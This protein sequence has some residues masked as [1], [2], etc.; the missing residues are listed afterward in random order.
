MSIKVFEQALSLA[1]ITSANLMLL[2]IL[3]QEE[4]G[5]PEALIYPNI[6]YYPGWNGRALNYT[7]NIGINLKMKDYR[8]YNHGALKLIHPV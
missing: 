3:S 5:S 4:E 7:K 6:D 2:H 1:K 8:C